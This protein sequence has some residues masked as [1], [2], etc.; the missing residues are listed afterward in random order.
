MRRAELQVFGK[1]MVCRDSDIASRVIAQSS[2]VNCVTINGDVH[3][4]KGTIS[5]G[6]R[7]ETRFASLLVQI[8]FFCILPGSQ[9]SGL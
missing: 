7:D 6:F 5:G 9:I 3:A 4:K 8:F 2:Q 1:W